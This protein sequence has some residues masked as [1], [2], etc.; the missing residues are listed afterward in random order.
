MLQPYPNCPSC[1]ILYSLSRK[2]Q[3][4]MAIKT[5]AANP[6]IMPDTL[7]IH[8]SFPHKIWLYGANSGVFYNLGKG[9]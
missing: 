6:E 9:L 3:Y 2:W 7:P 4:I 8:R 1:P 5:T